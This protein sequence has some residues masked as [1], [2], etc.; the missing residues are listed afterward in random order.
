[1]VDFPRSKY[2]CGYAAETSHGSGGTPTT[3]LGGWV[4]NKGFTELSNPLIIRELGSRNVA[5]TILGPF[6]ANGNLSYQ[7][8]YELNW[9]V[10]LI[11][12]KTGAGTAGNPTLLTQADL[13]AYGASDVKTMNFEI[14]ND[15]ST[16]D[17][18]RLKGALITDATF[19]GGIGTP[20]TVSA[21]MIAQTLDH[22]GSASAITSFTGQPVKATESTLKFAG[23]PIARVQN[24]SI[25][26]G[27]A[28]DE[29][30][31]LGTRF[32]QGYLLGEANY[33]FTIIARMTDGAHAEL[34]NKFYQGGTSPSTGVGSITEYA[35]E[36]LFS[37]GSSG[38][39]NNMDIRF[40][41]CTL[42]DLG[43]PI[44][45]GAGSVLI[46]V[47]GFG[48]SANGNTPIRLWQT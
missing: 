42:I 26:I 46:T 43:K 13:V 48:R 20:V 5:K 39:D 28:V 19:S 15:Q 30:R 31:E 24:Y 22:S 45:L 14:S 37:E 9:L 35:F 1:M 25:T 38:G 47:T 17:I 34:R 44:P 8:G 21:N 40:S 11:G 29:I 16:D 12:P 36:M 41:N 3:P 2:K 4:Q 6:A 32:N 27:N 18:D 7:M 10:H 33:L 23:T